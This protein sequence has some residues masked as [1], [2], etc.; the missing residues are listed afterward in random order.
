MLERPHLSA[1][2]AR[3]TCVSCLVCCGGRSGIFVQGYAI[4]KGSEE[5]VHD[6]E[7]RKRS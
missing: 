2:S 1:L 7:V 6:G 3:V 5:K 4:C